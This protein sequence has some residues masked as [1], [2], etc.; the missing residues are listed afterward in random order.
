M[1]LYCLQVNK[2]KVMAKIN[3]NNHKLKCHLHSVVLA[4]L[5]ENFEVDG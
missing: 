5:S 3:H 2:E 4:G 1:L